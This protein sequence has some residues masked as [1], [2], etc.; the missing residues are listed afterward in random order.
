M[1]ILSKEPLAGGFA[2]SA[3]E[4]SNECTATNEALFNSDRDTPPFAAAVP[5][6]NI[7]FD[8]LRCLFLKQFAKSTWHSPKNAYIIILYS[9]V[10]FEVGP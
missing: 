7:D 2:L 1:Y 9:S 10:Y 8:I 6:K 3:V 4:T 5:V